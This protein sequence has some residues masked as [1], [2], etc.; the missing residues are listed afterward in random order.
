MS[1]LTFL[2]IR[3]CLNRF[4]KFK[5]GNFMK[6]KSKYLKPSWRTFFSFLFLSLFFFG[7]TEALIYDFADLNPA[8]LIQGR[9]LYN[10]IFPSILLS[11]GV[12]FPYREYEL[13][14]TETDLSL[15]KES[16]DQIM[17]DH[18]W[19]MKKSDNTST[20]FETKN[21]FNRL[22]GN[23]FGT[24]IVSSYHNKDEIK[25]NGPH[26]IISNLEYVLKFRS[27][28]HIKSA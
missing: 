8:E 12:S 14:I 11:A 21:I 22:L 9:W 17:D 4:T 6:V 1:V 20:I 3:K 13:H 25:I 16:V 23:W 27:E 24:Q 26:G 18:G 5:N 2:Q 15:A 10:Y 19:K 7:V 28:K